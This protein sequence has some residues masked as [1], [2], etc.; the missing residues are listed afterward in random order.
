VPGST[1]IVRALEDIALL[2]ALSGENPFKVR[3]YE[4]GAQLVADLD[5]EL[6]ALIAAGQLTEVEGI[7][8]GLAKQIGELWSTGRS[9]LLEKLK[10]EQPPGALELAR[11]PGMTLRRMR[12]LHE[13]LGVSSIAELQQACVEQRVRGLPGFGVKTE[14]RLLQAVTRGAAPAP[15][16]GRMLLGHALRLAERIEQA[17]VSGGEAQAVSRAGAVRRFEEIV[18]ELEL[19]VATRDEA[20]VWRR[21]VRMPW[22][23]RVDREQRVALLSDGVPLIV[24]FTSEACAGAALLF[25]TGP[26]GH[27]H[28]LQSRARALGLELTCAGLSA[29]APAAGAPG[30]AGSEAE[31]YERLGLAF[32]PPEL[33]ADA[34]AEALAGAGERSYED[35]LAASDIRGMVHCHTTYSDGKNSIEEMA[36]AAEAMGMAYITITDHSPSAHYAGGLSIDRLKEQWDEIARVQERVG[37]RILRGAESDILAD[38]SLDYPDAVLE[39]LDVVIA[40]IH[41]RF[42]L[43]RAGMTARLSRAMGLP[44]FKIWGHALGRMLLSRDPI[45][46]DVPAVLD[47]LARARG[48][49]ELNADPHR[50]DLPPAW[51]RPARERGIRFVV[52]VD[53][54]SIEGLRVLPLGIG[55]AR[56]GGLR[57]HEVLN[58]LPAAE[59]AACVRPVA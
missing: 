14:Q 12:A 55:M 19:V 29:S 18:T 22:V 32:V 47:T 31:I 50:L 57:R 26:V 5:D 25:A 40:S 3:A 51:I 58:T 4:R 28:A 9:S 46:C 44:V 39:Q 6:A 48:A 36:R 52:S 13:G 37:V 49:I 56:R 27:V 53:A 15:D 23:L 21:I 45:D 30:H 7:G 42:K 33:R 16:K 59:F 1:E 34:E 41:S 8:E 11:V 24:H 20:A 43:D 2:L 38:G 17:L 10:S 54:H 35:L